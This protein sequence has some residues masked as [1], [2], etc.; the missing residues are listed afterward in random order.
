MRNRR[1]KCINTFEPEHLNLR[2]L[3]GK[4]FGG[5]ASPE[6][7]G[8]RIAE[9]AN[10]RRKSRIFANPLEA[11]RSFNQ[12]ILCGMRARLTSNRMRK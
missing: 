2:I 11:T 7:D 6:D 9:G 1:D 3:I 12:P 4:R 5:S 8:R 10:I